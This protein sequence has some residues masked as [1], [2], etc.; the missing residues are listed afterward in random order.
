MLGIISSQLAGLLKVEGPTIY[1]CVHTLEAPAIYPA[2]VSG[3]EYVESE[4]RNDMQG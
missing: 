1:L 4:L 3:H 2:L